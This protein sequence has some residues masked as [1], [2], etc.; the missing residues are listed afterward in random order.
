MR[1]MEHD[2]NTFDFALGF[3]GFCYLT[4]V[5]SASVF[6]E[7]GCLQTTNDEGKRIWILK[8]DK[9]MFKNKGSGFL[10]KS[11]RGHYKL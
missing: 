3:N 5:W 2:L 9:K 11:Q 6:S 10:E 8:I 1:E 4:L 7:Q